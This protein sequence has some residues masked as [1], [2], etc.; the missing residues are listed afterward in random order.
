VSAVRNVLSHDQVVA[1]P[2]TVDLLTAAHVL[3]LG[4]TTAYTLAQ[5]GQFGCRVFRQGGRYAVA[6][7]DLLRVLGVADAPAETRV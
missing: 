4:R 5:R 3:R 1:L 7:G 6:R 2:V